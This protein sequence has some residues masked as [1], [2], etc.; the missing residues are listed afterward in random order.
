MTSVYPF[1]GSGPIYPHFAKEEFVNNCSKYW[2]TNILF[3]SNFYPDAAS[4]KCG[5]HL[6]YLSTEF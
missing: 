3:I 6:Q 1:L 2:Y 5:S 4:L